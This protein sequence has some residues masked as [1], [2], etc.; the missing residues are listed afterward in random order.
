MDNAKRLVIGVFLT[1]VGVLLF[2]WSEVQKSINMWGRMEVFIS[3]MFPHKPAF[4]LQ[5]YR[6]CGFPLITSQENISYSRFYNEALFEPSIRMAC[7]RY[8]MDYHLVKAVIHAESAFNNQAVSPKGAM[9]LMQLMPGTSRQL[10]VAT[11]STPFRTSTA[12]SRLP[13]RTTHPLQQHLAWALAAYNA[14]P[15]AVEKHR[16]IPPFSETVFYVQR[17]LQLYRTYRSY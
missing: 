7:G 13:Q 12:V 17:V 14:G 3:P 15:E 11:H 1:F 4:S 8:G 5:F 2:P 9:G 6:H 10:G 16:G